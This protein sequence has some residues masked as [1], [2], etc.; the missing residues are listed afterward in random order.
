MLQEVILLD[1]K[2]A[3]AED[4]LPKISDPQLLRVQELAPCTMV[5]SEQYYDLGVFTENVADIPLFIYAFARGETDL[6]D[7]EWAAWNWWD[8]NGLENFLTYSGYMPQLHYT[9]FNKPGYPDIGTYDY[10]GILVTPEPGGSLHEWWFLRDD[11]HGATYFPLMYVGETDQEAF[12]KTRIQILL[13][14]SATSVGAVTQEDY[15]IERT[16]EQCEDEEIMLMFQ[17]R[18][19]EWSFLSFN[20][21][22]YTNLIT[23]G[24]RAERIEEAEPPGRYRYNVEG[25]DIL[26]LNTNWM[27]EYQNDLI[28][29]LMQTNASFLVNDDGSLEQVTVERSSLTMKTRRN[30]ELFQYSMRVR[31]SLDNFVP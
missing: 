6:P 30:D 8:Y 13:N 28:R 31:K 26:T 7:N 23:E 12:Q 25:S 11:F 21:K 2:D 22:H 27:Y 5:I 9:D 17:N 4:D 10:I 14:T 18:F 19:N 3:T 20:L 16:V 29:D 15:Y 1:Y 24:Q